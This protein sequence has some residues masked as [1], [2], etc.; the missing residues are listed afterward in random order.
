MTFPGC[1]SKISIN[2]GFHEPSHLPNVGSLLSAARRKVVHLPCW[3]SISEFQAA[4][5]KLGFG[6]MEKSWISTVLAEDIYMWK[7]IPCVCVYF[8]ES[9]RAWNRMQEMDM[10]RLTM[11]FIAMGIRVGSTYIVEIIKLMFKTTAASIWPLS[12]YG[13]TTNHPF[14]IGNLVWTWIL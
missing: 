5:G 13:W 9:T 12:Q 4:R 14:A 1:H 11:I 7:N 2:I 3:V 6:K 8:F 10:V